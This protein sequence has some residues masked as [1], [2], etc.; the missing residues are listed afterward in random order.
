MIY[1][2]MLDTGKMGNL[3]ARAKR[4]TRTR[5]IMRAIFREDFEAAMEHICSIE[6]I[7]TKANGVIIVSRVR[8]D[9]SETDNY[10]L[11]ESFRMD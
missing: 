7:D 8:A 5:I 2:N 3:M 9:Y 1:Q 6:I 11:K 4:S 10:F